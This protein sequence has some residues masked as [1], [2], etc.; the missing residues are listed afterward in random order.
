MRLL[1]FHSSPRNGDPARSGFRS[2]GMN[3]V[4]VARNDERDFARSPQHHER[5]DFTAALADI[6]EHSPW[7]AQSA[8]A[9]RPF[10]SLA[11]LHDAMIAAVRAA[12]QTA[13]AAL[14]AH[15]DLA[16]KAARAGALT[17]DFDA[18]AAERR[19]R[20]AE[21]AGIC[22]LPPAQRRL[23]GKVR[24]SLHRLCAPAQQGFRSCASSSGGLQHGAADELEAALAEIFLI[25]ALRLDQ[26]V[27]APDRLKVDR[28][29]V[30]ACARHACGRRQRRASDRACASCRSGRATAC[31]FA[32]PPTATAAP[33]S[34]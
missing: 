16:G 7:V 24:H 32:P 26:K 8:S 13:Q 10:A 15:P 1:I 28:A 30:D 33:T 22:P 14:R 20:P 2:P 34:R 9:R 12:P 4:W 18:R 19:P 29:A 17:A 6:Y 31:W 25:A 3:R 5:R 21:R 11:A 27:S 23:P